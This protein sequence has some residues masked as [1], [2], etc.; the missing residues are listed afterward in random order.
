MVKTDP[1]GS[2]PGFLARH[3]PAM[4]VTFSD[5]HGVRQHRVSPFGRL[6]LGGILLGAFAWTT[7][8][9]TTILL[10]GYDA[11]AP[12]SEAQALRT[13]YEARLATLI[14]ERDALKAELAG[15]V[16]L[17]SDAEG[18]LLRQQQ[19]IMSLSADVSE[20]GQSVTILRNQLGG[21]QT[22]R[23][24][25]DADAR[26]LTQKLAVLQLVLNEGLGGQSDV[27]TTIDTIATALAETAARRDEYAADAVALNERIV[28]IELEQE[29]NRQRQDRMLTQLEGAV[30]LTLVPLEN[31][32][33]R[34]GLDVDQI[35][36]SVQRNYSG[37]GGLSSDFVSAT[38]DGSGADPVALRVSAI[39]ESLDQVAMLS[40]AVNRTPLGIPVFGSYRHTSSFGMRSG[41]MHKGTDLAGATGTTIVASADGVVSFAGRQSG[42]GNLIKIRHDFGFETYYAHLN[43]IGV[44][45]GERVTRGQRIG[46]MGT[47]GRSSGVHLHYE[48]HLNGEAIDPMTYIRVGRDVF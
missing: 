16:S 31:I 10:N 40:I 1:A 44:T 18:S 6:I 25:A 32:L 46:G 41:R 9:T 22:A 8:A 15:R 29:L 38:P 27:A 20:Q 13:A 11:T 26:I 43:S 30:R 48:I 39:M 24:S 36:E 47:T 3:L 5:V 2:K 21:L 35:L 42:F 7:I 34:V 4:T 19:E 37:T 45:V 12:A 23:D 28:D 33:K 14:E 17:L